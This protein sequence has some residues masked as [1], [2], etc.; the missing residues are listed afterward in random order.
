MDGQNGLNE[1]TDSRMDGQYSWK[2]TEDIE[3]DLADLLRRLCGQWKQIV[4]CAAVFALVLGGYGWLKGRDMPDEDDIVKEAVLT[5]AEEQAVADAVRLEGEI[6]ELETYLDNSL[7]MQ[8][9]PYHKNKFVML[10]CID[11]AKR[12]ELPGITE[13]YLNFVQNGGAADALRDT[14]SSWKMDKSYLAEVITAYQK[15]YSSPYQVVVDS[16]EDKNQTAEALFYV[17]AVGRDAREAEKLAVDMQ[18]AVEKYSAKVKRAAGSHRLKLLSSQESVTVDSGLQSQQRD[19]K[20]LLSSN[21]TNLKAMTDAFSEEQMAV[22]REAADLKEEEGGAGQDAAGAGASGEGS[23]SVIKYIFLGIIAG[24]FVYCCVFSCW[25]IFRDTVKSIDEMRRLYT[26]PVYGEIEPED[27]RSRKKTAGAG[28]D[29]YGNTELQVLNRIRL[30]CRQRG[31]AKL[32]AASDFLLSEPEKGCLERMA[33]QLK[34]WGIDMTVAENASA[35]TAVWDDLTETGNVLLV[36]RTGKTTHRM[37]DS[38]ME[39]YLLNGIDVAGA[40]VFGQN[41]E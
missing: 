32:C 15:T 36:C 37:I 33:V 39:F 16:P 14:D 35:D 25:Y 13:S 7:L 29:T 40:A 26:F 30:A 9:E 4:V 38:A 19:R 12:Q 24:I 6:R 21:K 11:N 3:I 10:Y 34:D 2:R 31:L 27:R 1:R 8:I 28:Q 41:G 22:Y 17:E 20:A 5:E 18:D 23:G